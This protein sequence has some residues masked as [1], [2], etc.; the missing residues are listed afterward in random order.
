VLLLSYSLLV[1][2]F[3]A[4]ALLVPLVIAGI[5]TA[6]TRGS[7]QQDPK[8]DIC[9]QFVE[10]RTPLHDRMTPRPLP[11]GE[12]APNDPESH[13]WR[14]C[15]GYCTNILRVVAAPRSWTPG[16]SLEQ[17][18]A[19]E[20]V[21]TPTTYGGRRP[22]NLVKERSDPA[23]VDAKS[24]NRVTNSDLCRHTSTVSTVNFPQIGVHHLFRRGIRDGG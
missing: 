20:H 7:T 10:K 3:S 22:P 15:F 18:S 13:I 16:H 21:R 11:S 12:E 9:L 19:P 1:Q 24:Y 4:L 2:Q 14:S 17:S 23:D 6:V 5:D 8:P